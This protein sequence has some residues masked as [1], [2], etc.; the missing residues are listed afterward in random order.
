LRPGGTYELVVTT[1]VT[2]INGVTLAEEY[3]AQVISR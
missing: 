3:H 1:G 2:D